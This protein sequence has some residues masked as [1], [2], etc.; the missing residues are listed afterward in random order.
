MENLFVSYNIAL[1]AKNNGYVEKFL[2][3]Y[4]NDKLIIGTEVFV[5]FLRT[6]IPAPLIQ[7]MIDWFLSKG[8]II[9]LNCDGTGYEVRAKEWDDCSL[10]QLDTINDAFHKAFKMI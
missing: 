5:F 10:I 7:Q 8:I 9:R 3:Y 1:M 4:A 2:G 6:Y